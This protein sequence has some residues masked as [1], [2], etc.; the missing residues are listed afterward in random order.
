VTCDCKDASTSAYLC[1]QKGLFRGCCVV[2]VAPRTGTTSAPIP[3]RLLRLADP[4][5]TMAQAPSLR[6]QQKAW[7][8]EGCRTQDC[9]RA[10]DGLLRGAVWSKPKLPA[11]VLWLWAAKHVLQS[12]QP[13]HLQISR[14]FQAYPFKLHPLPV[15]SVLHYPVQALPR[16]FVHL[17]PTHYMD[18]L[19]A[20]WEAALQTF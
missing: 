3:S 10:C 14:S 12:M 15:Y 7:T 17:P 8:S 5:S 11:W 1:R 2:Q 20:I 9:T 19:Y 13:L 16:V 18:A 6:A 4:W